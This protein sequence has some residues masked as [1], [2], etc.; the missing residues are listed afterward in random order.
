MC[1][2]ALYKLIKVRENIQSPLFERSRS[3]RFEVFI[4]PIEYA[5]MCGVNSGEVGKRS[6]EKLPLE[7]TIN[8]MDSLKAAQIHFF[9]RHSTRT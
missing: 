8:D 1:T 7:R 5:Q 9:G 6:A 2:H 4:S 3:D